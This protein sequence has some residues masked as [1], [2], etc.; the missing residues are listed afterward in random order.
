MPS[1][2]IIDTN[3]LLQHPEILSRAG[4][5]KLVIPRAVMHELSYR[6]KS[7]KWSDITDL[8]AS[9]I[10]AGVLIVEAPE[11]IKND[12]FQSDRN[13]QRLT[14]AD[15]DIARI[16]ISYAERQGEEVPCVVTNDRAL[17]YFLASRNIT[18]MTG[19]EFINESKGD[20]LNKEIE[21]KAEKAVSSQKRYLKASFVLGGLASLVA[22]IVYSNMEVLVSTITV[23]GTM[24]GLPVLGLIL[25]WYRENFRL[26][27]GVFEC[28]IGVIMSYYVLFPTFDYS[29]LGVKEG[30]QI[31]GGLYAM[32]RGLDNIGKGVI[33]TRLE[34]LWL[35]VF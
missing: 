35:K 11:K 19:I 34:T 21:E 18:S 16:A 28:C 25:F 15:F 1:R 13:A 14:G 5:R 12:I 10:P 4:N 2:Y 33:G 7:N 23:W 22:N 20:F 31:L 27:Y 9:S 17:S 30:I 3:V 8:V 6:G 24:M 32:V 29:S 26:S